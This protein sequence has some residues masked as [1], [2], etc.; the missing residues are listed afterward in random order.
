MTTP[1]S[2]HVIDPPAVQTLNAAQ[3]ASLVMVIEGLLD[4][5][6]IGATVT[7]HHDGAVTIVIPGELQ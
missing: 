5:A 2:D 1:A 3:R 4:R 7:R 6:S